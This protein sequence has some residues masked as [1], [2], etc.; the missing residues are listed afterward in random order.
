MKIRLPQGKNTVETVW[1]CIPFNFDA[2]QWKNVKLLDGQNPPNFVLVADKGWVFRKLFYNLPMGYDRGTAGMFEDFIRSYDSE[3]GIFNNMPLPEWKSAVN[4]AEKRWQIVFNSKAST[5]G[6]DLDVAR[7]IISVNGTTPGNCRRQAVVLLRLV[8]RTNPHSGMMLY[9][10]RRAFDRKTGVQRGQ[11]REDKVFEFFRTLPEQD[12]L[13]KPLLKPEFYHL[14]ANGTTDFSGKYSIVTPPFIFEPT[15]A[16]DFVY[17]F[18]GD[19]P[20]WKEF[21]KKNHN[22]KVSKNKKSNPRKK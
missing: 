13:F 14:Y 22:P 5:N 20:Q 16:D 12:F 6:V 21:I 7:K 2:D 19:T 1:H 8:D 10:R 18:T 9:A 3:D 15:C 11:F 4:P 17:G